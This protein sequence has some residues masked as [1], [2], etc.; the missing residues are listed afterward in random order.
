MKRNKL[1]MYTLVVLVSSFIFSIEIQNRVAVN[2]THLLYLSEDV[3]ELG[4]YQTIIDSNMDLY[5]DN[6]GLVLSDI[7]NIDFIEAS[8]QYF[9]E[10][11]AYNISDLNEGV[12]ALVSRTSD[13]NIDIIEKYLGVNVVAYPMIRNINMDYSSLIYTCLLVLVVLLCTIISNLLYHQQSIFISILNGKKKRAII[14]NVSQMLRPLE[15]VYIVVV[16]MIFT[17]LFCQPL[18]T[19]SILAFFGSILSIILLEILIYVMIDIAYE[20]L[21]RVVSTTFLNTRL[22]LIPVKII[23]NICLVIVTASFLLYTLITIDEYSSLNLAYT[24][25]EEMTSQFGEL[26]Y[27]NYTTKAVSDSF[28]F[29]IDSDIEKDK[30]KVFDFT[31]DDRILFTDN[32]YISHHSDL[33][34]SSGEIILAINDHSCSSEEAL[35]L[36]EYYHVA[37]CQKVVYN[38][39]LY[40][41]IISYGETT[42]F[43]GGFIDAKTEEEAKGILN[44]IGSNY[45][46]FQLLDTYENIS[47]A[48]LKANERELALLIGISSALLV[49][50]LAM[51]TMYIYVC[52]SIDRTFYTFKI[53]QGT[54]FIRRYSKLIYNILIN[55]AIS[56]IA[57][58]F[59]IPNILALVIILL[60]QLSASIVVIKIFDQILIKQTLVQR[61]NYD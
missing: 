45:R 31:I 11:K 15:Y 7:R 4:D 48:K 24:L 14:A 35:S 10:N 16:A 27:A 46:Y 12:I 41:Y 8:P 40:D 53:L 22:R 21:I 17:I 36:Q 1:L 13:P 57:V 47:E 37:K 58:S 50:L 42:Y 51:L 26:Y 2:A 32:Y 55:C 61:M 44:T 52:I 60:M 38:H 28:D 29:S 3:E 39:E 20:S 54:P 6:R 43:T 33:P 18:N 30:L 59:L 5:V 49:L 56:V 19:Y 23:I 34:I 9:Y 25:E